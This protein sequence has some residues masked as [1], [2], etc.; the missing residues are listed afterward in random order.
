[1]C[2]SHTSRPAI[3]LRRRNPPRRHRSARLRPECYTLASLRHDLSNSARSGRV[4]APSGKAC[5]QGGASPARGIAVSGSTCASFPCAAMPSSAAMPAGQ[6]G[7]PQGVSHGT[8]AR[9]LVGAPGWW[10][11]AASL[12]SFQPFGIREI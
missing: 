7:S 12:A 6:P 8:A 2:A 3:S 5:T 10:E 9:N 11:A 1:L 4:A